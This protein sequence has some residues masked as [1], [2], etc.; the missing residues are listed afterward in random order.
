MPDKRHTFDIDRPVTPI[1]HLFRDFDQ[2]PDL[3]RRDHFEEWARLVD[4]VAG[5]EVHDECSN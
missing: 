1:E 2:G 5:G 4:K 3:S